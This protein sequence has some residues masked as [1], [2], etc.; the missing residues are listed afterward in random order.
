[1]VTASFCQWGNERTEG[2]FQERR[3]IKD[4]GKEEIGW[5]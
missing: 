2:L 4:N 5:K 3:M 1:M